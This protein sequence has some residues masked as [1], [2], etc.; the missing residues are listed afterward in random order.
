MTV[1]LCP[2][3]GEPR[4]VGTCHEGVPHAGWVVSA[5]HGPDGCNERCQ[6]NEHWLEGDDQ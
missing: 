4:D 2:R 6:G 5:M 1:Q 3:C